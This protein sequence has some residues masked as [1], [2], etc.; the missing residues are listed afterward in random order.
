MK[1]NAIVLFHCVQKIDSHVISQG[2]VVQ[3]LLHHVMANDIPI[4][5]EGELPCPSDS[6]KVHLLVQHV[7]LNYTSNFHEGESIEYS[8]PPGSMVISTSVSLKVAAN[9]NTFWH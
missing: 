4:L 8:A 9:C 1:L 7:Q 6:C 5:L 2:Q 3:Q